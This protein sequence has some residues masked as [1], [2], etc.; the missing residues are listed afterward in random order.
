VRV[1]ISEVCIQYGAYKTAPQSQKARS[2]ANLCPVTDT[3]MLWCSVDMHDRETL[4]LPTLAQ[5]RDGRQYND[6]VGR[7]LRESEVD[8]P[9]R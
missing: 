6:C 2:L 5:H 9:V 8:R 3:Y 7:L 4:S 1:E